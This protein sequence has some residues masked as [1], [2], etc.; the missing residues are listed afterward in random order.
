MTPKQKAD[1]LFMWF[2]SNTVLS[3]PKCKLCAIRIVDEILANTDNGY[4]GMEGCYPDGIDICSDEEY[5]EAV[6]AE[7]EKL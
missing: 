5:W 7:I 4:I 6:K 3:V 1:N 2:K